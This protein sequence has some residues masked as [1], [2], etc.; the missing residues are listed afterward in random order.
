MISQKRR[1]TAAVETAVCLPVVVLVMFGSIELS[2][3]IFQQ[4][5]IRGTLHECAKVAAKGENTGTDVRDAAQMMLSQMGINQ[6]DIQ[7]DVVTR[8]VNTGS[9]A[10]PTVTSFSIPS[11]GTPTP[12]LDQVPRGTILRMVLTAPRPDV[13]GV[14][15]ARYL[16]SSVTGEC[17]FVK[18]L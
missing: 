10:T 9:V 2:A 11:S 16:N 6:F 18:E 12:G 4:H 5:R 3:G 7:I 14:G 8:T 13:A 1:A 15:V 17:V